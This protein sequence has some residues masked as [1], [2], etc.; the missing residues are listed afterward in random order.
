M[1]DRSQINAL[2]HYCLSLAADKPAAEDLLQSSLERLLN[3]KPPANN[4]FAYARKIIRN[5][6]IDNCR[7]QNIVDF[8]ALDDHE[9]MLLDEQDLEKMTID[10]NL[11]EIF[12]GVLGNAEREVLFLWAVA[13]FTASEIAKETNTARGTVLARLYRIR[14]KCQNLDRET[15]MGGGAHS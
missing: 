4:P 11:I 14:K 8:E 3:L 13:G 12:M 2:F 6:F 5:Q 1:L 15:K 9:P 7:R 10:A